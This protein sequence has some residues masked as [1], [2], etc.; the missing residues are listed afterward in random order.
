MSERVQIFIDGGNFYHLVLKKLGLQEGQFDF[1]AFAVFLANGRTISDRGKRFYAGTVSEKV[2][3]KRSLFAMSKQVAFLDN[4]KSYNWET[5]TSKLKCRTEELLIDSRVVGYKELLKKGISKIQFQREREKGID[6]KLA[7]DLVTAAVDDRYDTAVVVSSD[8][9][10]VPA[11]DWVRYRTKKKVEYIGF[12]IPDLEDERNSTKPLLSI[13][14]KTD[15]QRTLVEADLRRF[16]IKRLILTS[17]GFANP[18]TSEVLLKEMPKQSEWC[19]VAMVSY[20]QTKIEESYVVESK[21]EL[22]SIGFKNIR[23]I[24]LHKPFKLEHAD[25][26][27]VCGGNTFSILQKMRQTGVDKYLLDSVNRGSL[28]VGV[29]AGSIIAGKSIEIAGWGSEGDKNDVALTE[30]SGLELT[31]VAVFPHYKSSQ[32]AELAE[33]KDKAAYPVIEITDN[34]IVLIRGNKVKKIGKF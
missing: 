11:I 13:I 22:E 32:S 8:A 10:L 29:S 16:T 27:Y 15:V 19:R 31:D 14:S 23:V 2:G 4:L 3:D 21:K 25:V 17:S 5:K 30:L 34:Q 7:T 12:S 18:E 1:E 33:F 6:V 9:D 24:N 28:Y 26:V 20:A